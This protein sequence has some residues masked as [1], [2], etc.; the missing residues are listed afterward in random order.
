MDKVLKTGQWAGYEIVHTYSRAQAIAD[1]VL[2]DLSSTHPNET[3]M[4]KWKIACTSAVWTMIEKAAEKD[5]VQTEIY[6]W[7]VCYMALMAIRAIKDSGRPELYFKVCLPLRERERKLKL[8]SGPVGF[9][10]PTPCLTIMLPE[11]D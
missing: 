6:C 5:Q 8:V 9:D 1:G 4:F 10:D 11:E 2:V 3:R 7:D